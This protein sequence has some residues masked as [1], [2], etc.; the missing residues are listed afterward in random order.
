[1][2]LVEFVHRDPFMQVISRVALLR[3]AH[4]VRVVL[5]TSRTIAIT[6]NTHMQLQYNTIHPIMAANKRDTQTKQSHQADRRSSTRS[7]KSP[8]CERW[9]LGCVVLFL[10][11]SFV[12]LLLLGCLVASVSLSWSLFESRVHHLLVSIFECLSSLPPSS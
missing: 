1:M 3:D 5:Q 6:L 9:E 7:I 11:P 2:G 10:V 4:G 8:S 12:L